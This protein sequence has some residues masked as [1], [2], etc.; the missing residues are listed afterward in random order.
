PKPGNPARE[1]L[2]GYLLGRQ[3]NA[4]ILPDLVTQFEAF[5]AGKCDVVPDVP[6]QMLTALQLGKPE[7]MAI[8]K[9]APWQMTRMNLNT[10][11]RHGV[12]EDN[13]MVTMVANR[14]ANPEAVKRARVFPYQLLAAF[15]SA[16][17]D[18][19]GLVREALQDAMEV[20]TA[21]VP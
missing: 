9:K 21:N 19:P 11:A 6:F 10:F 15:K 7:W 18:V 3:H 8:A 2:Y 4:A 12:F 13:A 20:A 17:G 1:A 5:K 16:G 14:L